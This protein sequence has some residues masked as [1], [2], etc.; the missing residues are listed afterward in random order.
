MRKQNLFIVLVNAFWLVLSGLNESGLLDILPFEDESLNK[1]IKWIVAFVVMFVN[2]VFF[3]YK[4]N[5]K[6][7]GGG[8][9]SDPTGKG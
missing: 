7:I 1:W 9:V 3:N 4:S 5:N 2:A 8:G 6:S